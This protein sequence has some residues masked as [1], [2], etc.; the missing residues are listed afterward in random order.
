[1]LNQNADA[2]DFKYRVNNDT[3]LI[4]GTR[5]VMMREEFRGVSVKN[6]KIKVSDIMLTMG[7]SDPFNI[8]DKILSWVKDLDYN[9]H[10][11]VGPSLNIL[12]SLKIR[13][14]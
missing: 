8:T 10:V 9:F 11:V 6:I 3:K 12:N 4:L 2:E 5:Y 7:G 13:K 1:M 14:Q